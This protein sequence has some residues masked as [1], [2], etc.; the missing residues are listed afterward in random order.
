MFGLSGEGLHRAVAGDASRVRIHGLDA[1]GN[2]LRPPHSRP[3]SQMN[4]RF[5]MAIVDPTG[6]MGGSTTAATS[7]SS[8]QGGS[9]LHQHSSQAAHLHSTSSALPA[10]SGA[11]RRTCGVYSG[12]GRTRFG[13][14]SIGESMNFDGAWIDGDQYS[15][16]FVAE[17]AGTFELH[18]W[19]ELDN[20]LVGRAAREPLP[21]SPF[22]LRVEP[23]RASPA[24]SFIMAS[25]LLKSGGVSLMAGPTDVAFRVQLRDAYG[26]ATAAGPGAGVAD[27]MDDID[28][29]IAHELGRTRPEEGGDGAG[30]A[31]QDSAVLS[32]V[33]HAPDGD[34]VLAFEPSKDHLGLYAVCYQPYTH[35]MLAGEY[36]IDVRLDDVAVVDAP[37]TFQVMPGPPDARHC[38][39]DAPA[40]ALVY[41]PFSNHLPYTATLTAYDEYG[42]R[43]HKGGANIITR[44]QQVDAT[45]IPAAT[46]VEDRKDGTY[47]ISFTWQ[48]VSICV[49]SIRVENRDFEPPMRVTFYDPTDQTEQQ[50]KYR[51]AVKRRQAIEEPSSPPSFSRP[52]SSPSS[53]GAG[54]EVST[55]KAVSPSV[56][57]GNRS[58]DDAIPSRRSRAASVILAGSRGDGSDDDATSARRVRAST[59]N[60]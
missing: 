49:L 17:T 31:A 45:G 50:R 4:V 19:A 25:D 33:V 20:G 41:D 58:D 36:E 18:L 9:P 53:G 40:R 15:L 46:T 13:F 37:L 16:A 34:H 35:R 1:F 60:L 30:G 48:R 27:A 21:G 38:V 24:T 26:N 44:A 55:S 52:P 2:P 51:E 8:P 14:D 57:H 47:K 3:L 6:S 23:S 59:A 12:D 11:P 29:W 43:L 56:S 22:A 54:V 39:L 10:Q 7:P 42:N 5:G 32:V 28:A